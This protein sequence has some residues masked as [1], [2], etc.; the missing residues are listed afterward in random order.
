LRSYLLDSF[1]MLPSH[2]LR[3]FLLCRCSMMQI[4]CSRI[5]H[6]HISCTGLLRSW[7][8]FRQCN[9]YICGCGLQTTVHR[10]RICTKTS[11]PTRTYLRGSSG[12]RLFSHS[13]LCALS[14]FH[15]FPWGTAY[16][17]IDQRRNSRLQDNPRK[18]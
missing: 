2:S 12:T 3:I 5:A 14:C 4:L 16:T 10:S 6:L 17:P 8:I 1:H 11:L 7:S 15:M 18:H 13:V 9:L